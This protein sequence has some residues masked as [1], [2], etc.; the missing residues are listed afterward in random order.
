M[1]EALRIQAITRDRLGHIFVSRGIISE[2]ELVGALSKRLGVPIFDP[3]KIAISEDLLELFPVSFLSENN[4]V[5]IERSGKKIV[6]AMV[7]PLDFAVIRDIEFMFGVVVQPMI[8]NQSDIKYLL[9]KKFVG[10]FDVKDI[11]KKNKSTRN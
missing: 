10:N 4:L 1:Q 3:E 8:A 7:D 2:E 9:E 5:P 6:I 11:I